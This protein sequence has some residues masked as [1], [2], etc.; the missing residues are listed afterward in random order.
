MVESPQI[1]I[2]NLFHRI[3]TYIQ[4]EKVQLILLVVGAFLVRLVLMVDGRGAGIAGRVAA[5]T[6]G[7]LASLLPRFQMLHDPDAGQRRAHDGKTLIS[8]DRH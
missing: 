7:G 3:K 4:Q 8:A 6:G 2:T 1:Q 5:S